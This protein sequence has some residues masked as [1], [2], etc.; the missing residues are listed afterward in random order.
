MVHRSAQWRRRLVGEAAMA[1]AAVLVA[2]IGW[3]S[4]AGRPS[5]FSR[6]SPQ[7]RA[8]GEYIDAAKRK[9]CL[10]VVDALSRRTRALAQASVAGRAGIERSF[11]DYSPA[12]ADL[13][14]FETDRIRLEDVSGPVA[15]VSASYTYER[16]FGF[17]GRGRDRHTYQ[18]VLEDGRWKIDLSEH[19]DP[20]SRGNRNSR[21]MFL[22]HQTWAA[23]TDHRRDTGEVTSDP[24]VIRGEL[25][26]FQFPEI[27][28]GVAD[29]SS[30]ADTL[31]VTTGPSV[32]CV[33]LRSAT[34][35]LVMIKIP[36]ASGAG[37][38]QYGAIP[39]GCDEQPLSRPYHGTSS[40]I[41]DGA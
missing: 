23:I 40:G 29:G 7:S 5:L 17:F 3:Y 20:E 22:V 4:L 11:C 13:S 25:P 35:T 6:D 24:S 15:Q 21:A 14:E 27:R 8:L 19:L 18:M 9:D 39:A 36:Q 2:L 37:T 33:S 26:G 31:F 16:F 10:V 28:Q 30:P 12:P 32:A 38:Y 1:F 34:G 41:R